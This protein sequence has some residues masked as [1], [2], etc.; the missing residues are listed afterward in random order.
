MAYNFVD[1]QYEIMIQKRCIDPM[2]WDEFYDL[3]SAEK[4]CNDDASCIG[5]EIGAGH[6]WDGFY[7][8][9]N[10]YR[11]S[12]EHHPKGIVFNKRGILRLNL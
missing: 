3:P 7:K 11:N 6:N 2:D 10:G 1:D 8:C 5:V 12:Y 4:A 9:S